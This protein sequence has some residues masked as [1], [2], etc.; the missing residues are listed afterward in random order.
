M[1]GPPLALGD[2]ITGKGFKVWGQIKGRL[3]HVLPGI[4]DQDLEDLAQ[5]ALMRLTRI[6]D[7]DKKPRSQELT[8]NGGGSSI[9]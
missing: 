7:Q 5:E 3:R 8:P 2:W 6:W 4:G 1:N 9:L